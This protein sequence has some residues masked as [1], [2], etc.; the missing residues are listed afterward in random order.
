VPAAA[1]SPAATG[2]GADAAQC[3]AGPAGMD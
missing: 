2:I 1:R 3:T